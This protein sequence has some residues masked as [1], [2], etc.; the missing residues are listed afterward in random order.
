M[1]SKR[2]NVSQMVLSKHVKKTITA[3]WSCT[4]R[5][6]FNLLPFIAIVR[7]QYL[8]EEIFTGTKGNKQK[9]TRYSRYM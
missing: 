3:Q 6:G 4:L 5:I 1:Y 7:S 2:M 9:Q 8:C